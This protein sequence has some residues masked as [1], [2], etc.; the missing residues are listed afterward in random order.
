MK[1]DPF[2]FALN[3]VCEEY[4]RPAH[5]FLDPRRRARALYSCCDAKDEPAY[6]RVDDDVES[7]RH[8]INK[9]NYFGWFAALQNQQ[10]KGTRPQSDGEYIEPPSIKRVMTKQIEPDNKQDYGHDKTDTPKGEQEFAFHRFFP[11]EYQSPRALMLVCVRLSKII[12]SN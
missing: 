10:I 3:G 1:C 8:A 9:K 12:C 2:E 5:L 4:I 11:F 7:N 6:E